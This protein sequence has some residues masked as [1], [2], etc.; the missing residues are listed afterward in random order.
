MALY[1]LHGDDKE[2]IEERTATDI[3]DFYFNVLDADP[4]F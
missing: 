1:D 2:D 4:S 3:G